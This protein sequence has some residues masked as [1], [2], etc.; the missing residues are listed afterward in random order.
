MIIPQVRGK[1]STK[2]S[3]WKNNNGIRKP[4]RPTRISKNATAAVKEEFLTLMAKRGVRS[5]NFCEMTGIS[6]SCLRWVWEMIRR[7]LR[8]K[9]FSVNRQTRYRIRKIREK[10]ERVCQT[11]LTFMRKQAKKQMIRQRPQPKIAHK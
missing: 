9:F 4:F 10:K 3:K 5:Q 2:A 8:K 7:T 6:K 1:T 11:S